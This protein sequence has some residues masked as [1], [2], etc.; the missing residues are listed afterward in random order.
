MYTTSLFDSS[1]SHRIIYHLGNF[2]VLEYDKDYSISPDHAQ[3]VYFASLMNVKKRQLIINISGEEG[4][5]VQAGAMQ[6]LVGD[7]EASTNILGIDDLAKKI[8][9]SIVTNETAVKPLFIG[10]G[11]IVLEP[12]FR[13]I[14][15][16]DLNAWDNAMIIEDGTFLA[17]DTNV[18]L[19]VAG[20]KT[21]S[22][23]V[24][25]G[26]GLFNTALFG[27]GV[28]ALESSVPMEELILVNLQEDELRIDGNM[29]VAW[30]HD[31]DFTVKK[32]T[33]SLIGST[34]S[35]EGFVNVYKGTGKVLIAPVRH[36]KGISTPEGDQK[37]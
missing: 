5:I 27:T 26:E 19:K 31:L 2:S 29:A 11:T 32:A 15:L 28:V 33:K 8:A 34:V 7:I 12:S 21:L 35:K 23:M 37:K 6:F 16:Q 18:E 13:Y 20:R 9:G 1:E 10:D 24:L 3:E 14:I 25:G 22:S 30:S 36:N 4:A 17:C